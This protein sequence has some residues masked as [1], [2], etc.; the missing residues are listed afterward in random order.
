MDDSLS[1]SPPVDLH[2]FFEISIRTEKKNQ[3]ELKKIIQ[4]VYTETLSQFEI[5]AE[6][7]ISKNQWRSTGGMGSYLAKNLSLTMTW[8]SNFRVL[9]TVLPY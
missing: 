9:F 3:L 7:E 1:V 5:I 6:M 4:L 8:S 2:C